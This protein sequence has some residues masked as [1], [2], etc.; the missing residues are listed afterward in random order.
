MNIVNRSALRLFSILAVPAAGA[1]AVAAGLAADAAREPAAIY[2]AV[3]GYCHGANVGP[4]ILGRH[5]PAAA[6]EAIVRTGPNA[7][8]AFRPTEITDSELQHLAHW[9]EA[10]D[11]S[12]AEHGQ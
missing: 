1:S 8:P 3:C 10:S 12:A 7:M 5:I 4:I 9:I 11:P 6:I 2:A